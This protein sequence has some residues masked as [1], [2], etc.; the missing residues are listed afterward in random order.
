MIMSIQPPDSES[1]DREELKEAGA[2]LYDIEPMH[3]EDAREAT[4]EEH[5]HRIRE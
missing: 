4:P 2:G 3:A 1:A 5:E